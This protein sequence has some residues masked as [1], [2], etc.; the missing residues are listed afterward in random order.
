MK[1]FAPHPDAVADIDQIAEY[2]ALDSVDA[3]DK[4]IDTLF[5]EIEALVPFPGRGHRRPDLTD[6]PLRFIRVFDYLVA[7]ASEQRPLWVV[8]VLHGRRSPRAIAA[9]LQTRG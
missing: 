2:I 5:L 3:A 7:Y 8:A 9:I 4:V 6:R 1:G